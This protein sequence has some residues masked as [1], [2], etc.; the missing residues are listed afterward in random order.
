MISYCKGCFEKQLKIDELTE[1]LKRLKAK[2]HYRERKNQEGYFG[3]STPSSKV[4]LKGNT[5]KEHQGRKG[6]AKPGHPGHGRQ[7]FD[8]SGADRVVWVPPEVGDQCPR[9]G[10]PLEDKGIDDRC[11]I[12]IPPIK[13]ERIL[14][15]LP[16]HYCARCNHSYQPS[17]PGVL[18]RSLYGNEIVATAATMHYVHGIPLGRICGQ[19]G[20]SLGSLIK[21]FHR[22]AKLFGSIPDRL[23]E[24]YRQA[25]VKHAD[26]TGWRNDGQSGFAWLFATENISL[27]L[28]R[29]TRSA[30]VVSEVFGENP[31][32]GTLVVD[33]YS[34][35]N[36]AP[37]AQQYCYAHLLR[38]VEDVG[39]EFPDDQEVTSFVAKLAPLLATAMHLR[40]LPIPDAQF[41]KQAREVKGHILEL[42]HAPCKHLAIRHIQEIFHDNEERMYRWAEDRRVP[43]DNNLAERELRPTVIARKVSFGSQSDAGAHTRGVLMTTLHSL[44]KKTKT[45]VTSDLKEALDRFARDPSLDPYNLLFSNDTS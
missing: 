42:V 5:P 20:I 19:L 11:V 38:D 32:P 45:D 7:T 41:Y 6:G 30:R 29:K 24:R 37:C 33:R 2:L 1:E 39:K 27:F 3:S 44:K 18:P 35:Y 16:K 8:E 36:R 40:A 13:T 26:E 23:M 17:T 9:C 43:A 22:L 28:F 21:I 10:G 12:D 4:L 31:L 34:G 15:K 25:P 14:Y